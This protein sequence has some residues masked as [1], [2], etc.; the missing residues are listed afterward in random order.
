MSDNQTPDD[1]KT[2]DKLAAV[3]QMRERLQS[4]TA[5]LRKLPQKGEVQVSEQIDNK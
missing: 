5:T 2:L 4:M 3:R 1:K